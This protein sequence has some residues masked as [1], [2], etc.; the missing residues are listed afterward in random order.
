MENSRQKRGNSEKLRNRQKFRLGGGNLEKEGEGL[1]TA[2]SLLQEKNAGCRK[3]REGIHKAAK[4][5]V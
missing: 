2:Y 3:S 5:E 4:E 1:E